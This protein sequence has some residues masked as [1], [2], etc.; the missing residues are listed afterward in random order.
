MNEKLFIVGIGL[1]LLGI[2][3]IIASVILFAGKGEFSIVGF[4][5]PIPIAI[6]SK[7]ELLIISIIFSIFVVLYLMLIISSLR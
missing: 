2:F 3:F 6:A 5:G 4:I 7:K 1:I